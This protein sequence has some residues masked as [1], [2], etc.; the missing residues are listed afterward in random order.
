MT[1]LNLLIQQLKKKKKSNLAAVVAVES[2]IKELK[3]KY[4]EKSLI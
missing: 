1:N 2:E 4:N 3:S